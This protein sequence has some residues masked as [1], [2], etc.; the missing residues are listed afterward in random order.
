MIL[1]LLKK[2]AVVCMIAMASKIAVAM[3]M[4]YSF[5]VDFF[6]GSLRGTSAPVYVTLDGVLGVGFETFTHEVG[7]LNAFDFTFSGITYD[8]TLAE[9]Y[10]RWPRI[11][12]SNGILVSLSYATFAT[13]QK[14]GVIMSVSQGPSGTSSFVTIRDTNDETDR[15]RISNWAPV[16]N[17]V[18][19]PA[20][21]ALFGLGLAGLGWSRSKKR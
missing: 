15:G 3:P 7:N 6:S 12:L 13:P 11:V 2:I 5:D 21:L 1:N 18:P 14:P 16:K 8:M 20:T 17:T 9:G 19:A 10:P 4:D